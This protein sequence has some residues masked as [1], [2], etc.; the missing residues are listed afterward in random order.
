MAPPVL[1]PWA[2]TPGTRVRWADLR[3]WLLGLGNI[4]G[5]TPRLRD[6]QLQAHVEALDEAVVDHALDPWALMVLQDLL[7]RWRRGLR[8]SEVE[9]AKRLEGLDLRATARAHR[10]QEMPGPRFWALALLA[11]V[12]QR[13]RARL[14]KGVGEASLGAFLGRH[15]ERLVTRVQAALRPSVTT[16]GAS[17][18]LSLGDLAEGFTPPMLVDGTLREADQGLDVETLGERVKRLAT[19]GSA[20]TLIAP[21][22][23]TDASRDLLLRVFTAEGVRA[24]YRRGGHVLL[25]VQPGEHW[26]WGLVRRRGA[27]GIPWPAGVALSGWNEELA[28]DVLSRLK[29]A[30]LHITG[31]PVLQLDPLH[32]A[33]TELSPGTRA[34][35]TLERT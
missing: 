27:F 23:P 3:G 28:R 11:R 35:A 8:R 16:L 13:L 34:T 32:A 33:L 10:L 9:R 17:D 6:A 4:H 14:P 21:S 24:V 31:L 19:L 20:P 26:W 29:P 25:P 22:A 18:V 30:H 7:E 2:S 12:V 5:R 1:L 15:L